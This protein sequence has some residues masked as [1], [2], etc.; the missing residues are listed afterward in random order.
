MWQANLVYRVLQDSL[1]LLEL[2]DRLASGV[3][4]E[5]LEIPDQLDRLGVL[6]FEDFKAA[7]DLQDQLV[8]K[9]LKGNKVQQEQQDQQVISVA[10]LLYDRWKLWAVTWSDDDF[11]Y[12]PGAE[13]TQIT[14]I[15]II[16]GYCHNLIIIINNNTNHGSN[17]Q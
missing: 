9:V 11:M 4:L 16:I 1:G 3:L 14:D 7:L 12:R 15:I 10:Y 13:L 5:T 6:D 17:S 8:F 2:Q